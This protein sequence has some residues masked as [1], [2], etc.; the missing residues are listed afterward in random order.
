MDLE[1]KYQE[2]VYSTAKIKV[3]LWHKPNNIWADRPFERIYNFNSRKRIAEAFTSWLRI[4]TSE[5]L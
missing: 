5:Q 2:T 4:E 1:E 3:F